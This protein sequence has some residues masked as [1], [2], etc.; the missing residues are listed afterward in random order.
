MVCEV[1]IYQEPSELF[2]TIENAPPEETL[3]H[4]VN[5]GHFPYWTLSQPLVYK[6]RTCCVQDFVPVLPPLN[7][8]AFKDKLAAITEPVYKTRRLELP[9]TGVAYLFRG[10]KYLLIE[11]VERPHAR[12]LE[13]A[14]LGEAAATAPVSF[15]LHKLTKCSSTLSFTLENTKS[16]PETPVDRAPGLYELNEVDFRDE[17]T[18]PNGPSV[19][20]FSFSLKPQVTITIPT[21]C[22]V[23]HATETDLSQPDLF[24]NG[25]L[26]HPSFSSPSVK[27]VKNTVVIPCEC[28]LI[29]MRQLVH[30]ELF[31][32]HVK[33]YLTY[34]QSVIGKKESDSAK[35]VERI[36]SRESLGA[37][38]GKAESTTSLASINPEDGG[39]AI[40]RIVQQLDEQHAQDIINELSEMFYLL[41]L[42]KKE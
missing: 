26:A 42:Y 32:W 23:A 3:E 30:R 10:K 11:N 8:P 4:T 36:L 15:P 1:P 28:Q 22:P 34:I 17:E 39:S 16:D 31:S 18:V 25:E 12:F 13:E 7:T 33:K 41:K 24:S 5:E 6:L 27:A 37:S 9:E 29:K 2:E 19:F 14:P 20:L 38:M 40:P 21:G 35:K